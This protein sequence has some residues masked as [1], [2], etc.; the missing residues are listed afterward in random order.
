MI[1]Y[2]YLFLLGFYLFEA[3]NVEPAED[4]V[5]N[6]NEPE[7]IINATDNFTITCSGKKPITWSSPK[8]RE[9]STF[10][11]IEY[12][13]NFYTITLIHNDIPLSIK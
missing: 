9:V 1:Y 4:F 13:T 10:A 11:H 3:N 12:F 7:V 2:L 8:T 6:I 5:L